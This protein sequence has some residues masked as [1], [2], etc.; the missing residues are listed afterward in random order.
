MNP[1][2]ESFPRTTIHR[3]RIHDGD[4]GYI[5]R[6]YD[7][8]VWYLVSD[9]AT[10]LELEV[11]GP[12][13]KLAAESGA[14]GALASVSMQVWSN[15]EPYWQK[16][17]FGP[18]VSEARRKGGFELKLRVPKGGV[19]RCYIVPSKILSVVDV[20]SMIEAVEQELGRPV[21]W[22]PDRQIAIRSWIRLAAGGEVSMV[23]LLLEAISDELGAARSLR[24]DPIEEID[25]TGAL[26]SAPECRLVSIWA[27]RRGADIERARVRIEQDLSHYGRRRSEHMP[28]NRID[29]TAQQWRTAEEQLERLRELAGS[30]RGH[31]VRQELS[32]P[33]TFGAATQR[34]YRLRKLLRAF[35]PLSSEVLSAEEVADWSRLPPVTMNRLFECW[36]AVWLVRQ[37]RSLGFEGA[38]DLT[39]GA[40]VLAGATWT[41]KRQ[42]V[43]IVLDYEPHPPML[44]FSQVPA[45]DER[46]ESS[47]EWAIKRQLI[48]EQR[49]IFGSREECSPDY[50]LRI[51]GPGGRVLA[52]GD[53]CLADP[54]FHPTTGESKVAKVARY[55]NSL[56]WWAGSRAHSCHALGGFV[57]FPGP[58]MQW[59]RHRAESRGQ[60]VWLLCPT[61]CGTDDP[62]P[63]VFTAFLEHL[64]D[65]VLAP[66]G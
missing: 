48:D 34:D 17:E 42:D 18:Q 4:G 54:E 39:L 20:W 22:D 7:K 23:S 28:A 21:G 15:N 43:R 57:L 46:M 49:T 47:I 6:E 58:T 2:G 31:I 59:S 38:A 8:K 30:V 5:E 66:R 9:K 10:Y 41:L 50:L 12:P 29:S 55:R 19:L 63:Q 32:A 52:V 11:V 40:D 35:T 44:D 56:Y 25:A 45:V 61:P 36:G 24:R 60:D 53:A 65:G 51:E 27:V 62:T 26:R 3:V 14:P 64:L 37:I 33:V 13:L 1:P 16:W